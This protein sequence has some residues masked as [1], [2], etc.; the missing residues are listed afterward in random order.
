MVVVVV[1]VV[2]AV[3]GGHISAELNRSQ[4]KKR[5]FHSKS[6]LP[7]FSYITCYFHF[8]FRKGMGIY[9]KCSS[10]PDRFC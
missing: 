7:H 6:N 2:A 3:E 8:S 5:R 1:V 9:S 4:P 10:E